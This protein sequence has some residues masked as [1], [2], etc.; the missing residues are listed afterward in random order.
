M[1]KYKLNEGGSV[2]KHITMVVHAAKHLNT[3]MCMMDVQRLAPCGGGESLNVKPQ[4]N[5]GRKILLRILYG[6]T[7]SL[8]TCESR[9][10]LERSK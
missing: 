5:G 3:E 4:A 10:L 7:I 6:W 9:W 2:L 1:V 8:R